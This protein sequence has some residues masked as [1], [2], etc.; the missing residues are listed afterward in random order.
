MGDL[1]ISRHRKP[2]IK[3]AVGERGDSL[4]EVSEGRKKLA[5]NSKTHEPDE[6]EKEKRTEGSFP[7]DALN[8]LAEEVI[9][10]ESDEAM[11]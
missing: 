8:T 6:P 5:R 2:E 7:P 1:V 3:I 11:V 4:F 10:I 9:R